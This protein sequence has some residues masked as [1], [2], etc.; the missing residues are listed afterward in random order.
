MYKKFFLI[1]TFLFSTSIL[2]AEIVKS[3]KING[4]ERVSD[5]TI[6]IYGNIELNKDYNESDLNK[7]LNDLFS[8]NF[9]EDIRVNIKK[10]VLVI[11]LVEFAVVRNLIIVGESRAKYIKEIKKQILLKE[12]NSFIETDL[13]KSID[14]IKTL[15]SLAG[16]NFTEVNSKIKK[17]DNRSVDLIFEIIKGKETKISKIS[18]S[19]DK[20]IKEKRLRDVIATEEDKFWKFISR[21][22][23]YSERL[24]NLDKRLLINY[25]KSM[26]YYDVEI[27][28]SS[29]E[30][31]KSGDIELIYNIDAGKKFFIEKIT[32][33]VDAVFDKNLF[34]PLNKEYQKYIGS[35]YSPFKIKKLLDEIDNIIEDN[36][37]QFVEHSVRESIENDSINI[38]FI[39]NEGPKN[40]VE[41]INITGNN[42]TNEAVIRGELLL[43]EGDPFTNLSLD[44]SIS[45][46]KSRN[47]FNTVESSV[48]NGTLQNSKIIDIKV[49]E[50]PTGEISAGA[51]VGTNGG[52]LAFN[53][54]ENNWLGEGK[55]VGFDIE[56]TS[57]S[58]RGTVNYNNPNYDFMGNSINY[59]VSTS[60]ND[61]SDQ[62]YK[63][64]LTSAG[65]GTSFEQFKNVFANLGISASYDDLKTESNASKSL[66]KQA[67]AFSEI[68]ANYG[69]SYDKRN[70][71]FMPT[72][73]SIVSFNQSIPIY[74]D[75]AFIAN[76]LSTS[77]YNTFSE[78]LI[79]A[80]K[81]LFTSVNGLNDEDV[82]I[83][84][85]KYL[86]NSRL[87]GFERGRV[88]PVDGKDHIGGNYAASLNFEAQ[89]PKL[90]PETTKTDVA[91]FLDFG[92]VWGVDYDANIDDSN[93]IRSTTGA[94]LSWVSPIGPMSFIFSKNI[95]KAS[96]DITESFNF[97]L[98]TTF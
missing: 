42:I 39:I 51:G 11:D 96:T 77:V 57:E 78:D 36:N 65:I 71:S 5:E 13:S 83:S 38:K 15:Y 73:G 48:K 88:G 24:V 85:R 86:S 66:Q 29:A 58:L 8:T 10:N 33:D 44:K 92:N 81:F 64:K 59:F 67:G 53:I 79:G 37:L 3:V 45:K 56:L 68:A 54:Q 46:I 19:G 28:S 6:K 75:K 93:K 27:V 41:R 55:K 2:N 69:F 62:G 52:T 35:H 32:T 18:F 87:R 61:K 72:D 4:N 47:I 84:K 17:I 40:L 16:F 89:L 90:L 9:F 50:K 82:R 80:S 60:T 63:N 74:A 34:F 95:A 31:K 91:L 76:T 14:I 25:Y 30:I 49:E 22:T 70:R 26:G 12:K 94:A 7:I 1:I 43:D 98:G 97:N 23:S 20:K 21:N